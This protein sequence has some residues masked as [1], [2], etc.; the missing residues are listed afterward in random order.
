MILEAY[1]YIR[2]TQE[3]DNIL[4]FYDEVYKHVVPYLPPRWLEYD[5]IISKVV[6]ASKL[7]IRLLTMGQ[8]T[9]PMMRA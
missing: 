5:Y 8:Y 7:L 3:H 9:K 6:K 4:I 2:Y 1:N